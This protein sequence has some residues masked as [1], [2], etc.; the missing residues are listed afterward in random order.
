MIIVALTGSIETEKFFS[1]CSAKTVD[2]GR[3]AKEANL[4]IEIAEG[5][6]SCRITRHQRG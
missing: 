4:Y 5:I 1:I 6:H 2:D 3:G